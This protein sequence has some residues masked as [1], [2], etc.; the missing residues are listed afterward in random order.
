MQF[1]VPQFIDIE[2][3]VIGPMTIKQFLWILPGGTI[4]FFLWIS[5]PFGWFLLIG[6]PIAVFFGMLAFYKYNGRPFISLIN[7]FFKH[8]CRPKLFLW[9]KT[10]QKFKPII[11]QSPRKKT[12]E[13]KTRPNLQ[14]LAWRTDLNQ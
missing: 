10:N 3:K 13:K 8:L 12:Q 9:K 1:P 2:D 11:K 7:A 4:L 5:L 6:A 14:E